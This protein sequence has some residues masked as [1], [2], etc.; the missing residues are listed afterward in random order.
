MRK[1]IRALSKRT[2]EE[3]IIVSHDG[4]V[5]GFGKG[6]FCIYR[7]VCPKTKKQS[8][9]VKGWKNK[10]EGEKDGKLKDSQI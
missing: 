1:N 3:V 4:D 10:G 7:Q 2:D 5:P 6:I 9:K 8:Q